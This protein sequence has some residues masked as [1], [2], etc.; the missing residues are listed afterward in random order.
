MTLPLR[1]EKEDNENTVYKLNKSIYRLKQSSR[2][3]YRKPS[4]YLI[5][6]NF[7]VSSV[8]YSLWLKINNNCTIIILVYVDVITIDNNLEEIIRVKEK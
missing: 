4:S 5:S 8:G 7:N 6:C 2:A 3:W 1:H